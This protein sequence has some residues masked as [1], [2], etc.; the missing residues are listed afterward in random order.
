MEKEGNVSELR[1]Q[2]LTE[3]SALF[4]HGN[5][6]LHRSMGSKELAHHIEGSAKANGCHHISLP[7]QHGV[8]D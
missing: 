1:Q 2:K 6:L 7:T 3:P 5:V 4:G 8:S